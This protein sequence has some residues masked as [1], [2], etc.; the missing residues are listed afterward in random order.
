LVPIGSIE[1]ISEGILMKNKNIAILILFVLLIF[2]CHYEPV[3]TENQITIKKW[4]GLHL[5]NYNSDAEIDSLIEVLPSLAEIGINTLIFEVDY[6]FNFQSHPE[7]RGGESP[8]TINGASRLVDACSENKIRLIPEFQCLGHQSWGKETFPLLTVYPEFDLTPG[9]FPNND[10]IYCREWDPLNPKVYEIVFPLLD[11]IIDAFQADAM[12]VGMDE[13]FLLGHE[14]SPSTFGK[15]PAELYAKAIT[16]IYGHLVTKR[17]VEMLMWADRLIDGNVY[18]YGEW[19]A[20]VNGTAP[21]INMI[22]NDIIMC[23]W[24]YEERDTYPSVSM[25]LEKGFRVLPTGWRNAEATE[26]LI[27]DSFKYNDPRM[28]GHL[29]STWGGAREGILH[30]DPIIRGTKL[31]HQLELKALSLP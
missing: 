7:L 4:A 10:S 21:A 13:V 8:V 9:A 16:D 3:H 20:A 19:E 11:E 18:D 27:N 14:L 15:D 29:F 22:P 28:L 2:S 26:A 6:N 5:I 25:F 12:H 31:M 1:K 23:D 17:G 24:H 30:F